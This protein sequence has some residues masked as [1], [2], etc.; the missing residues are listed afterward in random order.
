MSETIQVCF[1]LFGLILSH[2]N[3]CRL[4]NAKYIFI[5]IDSSISNNSV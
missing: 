4:F 1:I 2:I 3:Y 5:E